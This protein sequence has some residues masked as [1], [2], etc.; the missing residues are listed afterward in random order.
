VARLLGEL[1]DPQPPLIT[2][3]AGKGGL[4]TFAPPLDGA[5]RFRAEHCVVVH[6]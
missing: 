5:A 6:G 4:A 2:V 1:D 3:A